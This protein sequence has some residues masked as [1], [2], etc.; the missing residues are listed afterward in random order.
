MASGPPVFHHLCISLTFLYTHAHTLIPTA[1]CTTFLHGFNHGTQV[2]VCV[3]VCACLCMCVC[4]GVCMPYSFGKHSSQDS[5]MYLCYRLP[6]V[7]L[8]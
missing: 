5:T 6:V 3:C 4:A 2:C 8:W 7:A 1:H